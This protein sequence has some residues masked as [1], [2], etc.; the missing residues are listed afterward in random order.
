MQS[1]AKSFCRRCTLV[2][3]YSYS[4]PRAH[5]Y[6]HRSLHTSGG[7]GG[8][9]WPYRLIPYTHNQRDPGNAMLLHLPPSLSRVRTSPLPRLYYYPRTQVLPPL[10]HL[11][12][13]Y[14]PRPL[15]GGASSQVVWR[16]RQKVLASSSTPCLNFWV[17]SPSSHLAI[18][19]LHCIAVIFPPIPVSA[20]LRDCPAVTLYLTAT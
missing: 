18:I 1:L 10:P 14:H 16:L 5:T 12:S 9:S 17:E 20:G 8:Q 7:L 6:I 11:L 3:T 15:A 4:S 19:Q 2:V 13:Y